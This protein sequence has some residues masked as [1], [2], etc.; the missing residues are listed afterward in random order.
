MNDNALLRYS[1]HIMLPEV[2]MRGQERW[3]AS[4]LLIVGLGGLGSPAALYLAAA[5]IGHL[6]LCDPD[7][8][9]VSNLQRQIIH[10]TARIGQYKAE[11]AAIAVAQLNPEVRV[12]TLTQRLDDVALA[13][14]LAKVD[15]VLDCSDNFATRFALNAACVAQRIPLISAA[16]VRME[17]QI[18]VFVPG[19]PCYRCL[20]HD[21]GSD[22]TTCTHNGILAPVVGIMGCMQALETLKLLA[23]IGDSLSG[24][25]LLFDAKRMEWQTLRLRRDPHCPICSQA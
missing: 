9:E 15:A 4:T 24:R 16:A 18:S 5:G 21:L 2:D 14:T 25:L 19:G 17:G 6:L 1:R 3:Q 22:D 13:H 20:Y 11:S 10:T 23:A 7:R 8:V 12:T